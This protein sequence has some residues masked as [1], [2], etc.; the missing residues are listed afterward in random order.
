LKTKNKS[1]ETDSLQSP[2][3]SIDPLGIQQESGNP[4]TSQHYGKG[5]AKRQNKT[6][7]QL[8]AIIIL[9]CLVEF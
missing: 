8:L 6:M 2:A 5:F 4:G 7:E 1:A 9:S 3:K